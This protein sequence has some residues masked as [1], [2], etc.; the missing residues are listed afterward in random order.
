MGGPRG[1]AHTVAYAYDAADRVIETTYPSG[2]IVTLSRDGMGRITAVTSK[3]SSSD[4]AETVAAAITWQPLSA[5]LATLTH[6]NGLVA[7]R[8]YTQDYELSRCELTD[9]A[10]PVIDLS[11]ARGDQINLTAITDNVTAANSATF[12]YSAANRLNSAA[13]P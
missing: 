4:P 11:Y 13:G 8:S 6:G 1:V 10:L 2:R 9:G 12:G 7:T 5:L 3:K